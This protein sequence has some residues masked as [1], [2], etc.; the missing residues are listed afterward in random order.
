MERYVEEIE[1]HTSQTNDKLRAFGKGLSATGWALALL[2][3]GFIAAA[4]GATLR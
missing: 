3:A 1:A 2:A 4:L